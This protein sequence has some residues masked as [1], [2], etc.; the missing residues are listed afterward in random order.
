MLSISTIA[1][2][3]ESS[4]TY[5]TVWEAHGIRVLPGQFENY[6]D[7]LAGSW[8]DVYEFATLIFCGVFIDL[9]NSP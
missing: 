7:H 1:L 6:M 8:K 5:G 9:D 4:Y 2:A 3:Q